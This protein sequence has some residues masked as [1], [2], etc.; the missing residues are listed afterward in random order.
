MI[1]PTELAISA[2]QDAARNKYASDHVNAAHARLIETVVKNQPVA[3]TMFPT[4]DNFE[5]ARDYL[6]ALAHAFDDIAYQVAS[7]AN[8]NATMHVS[9]RDRASI[10]SNALSDSGL[11]SDLN[12]AA[13][14]LREDALEGAA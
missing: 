1:S 9:Y 8:S 4:P 6:I 13:E 14:Q 11:L 7:E 2:A 5:D 10:F 12:E 3:F